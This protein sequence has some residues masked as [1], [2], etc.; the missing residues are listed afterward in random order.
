MM[1]RMRYIVSLIVVLVA[2][3]GVALYVHS[4]SPVPAA[5][6]TASSTPF[7]V[8]DYRC[9]GGRSIHAQYFKG[10][11]PPA[12][13]PGEP[14]TPTGHVVL[15]LSDGRTVTL[16]QTIAADGIRY[17]D[18]PTPG[19]TE[20]F[21]FWSKGNG[22]FITENGTETFANCIDINSPIATSTAPIATTTPAH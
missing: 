17:S 15:S 7:A 19:G 2:L 11:T 1:P 3:I 6:S 20:T 13:V 21:I 9:D 10:S 4:T 18:N 22:A 14:P 12:T 5:P 8:V 16:E